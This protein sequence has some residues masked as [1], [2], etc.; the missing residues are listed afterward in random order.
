MNKNTNINFYTS[1]NNK[2]WRNTTMV[3]QYANY[4]ELYTAERIM[5]EN[6]PEYIRGGYIL[7]LGVGGEAE[8]QHPILPQLVK[9]FL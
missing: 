2:S 6:L 8:E 5:L 4:D 1:I 3:K 9:T 7:D